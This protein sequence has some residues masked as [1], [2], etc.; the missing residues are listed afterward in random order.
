VPVPRDSVSGVPLTVFGS[1]SLPLLL[2]ESIPGAAMGI[3][4]DPPRGLGNAVHELV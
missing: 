1:P 4:W 2:D 3:S